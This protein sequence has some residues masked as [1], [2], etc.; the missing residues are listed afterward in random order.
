MSLD[1]CVQDTKE[2]IIP[3]LSLMPSVK[4]SSFPEPSPESAAL[5]NS[6]TIL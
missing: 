1:R 5:L 3:K 2:S 4:K 6:I